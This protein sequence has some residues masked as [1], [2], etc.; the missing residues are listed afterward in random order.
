MSGATLR[1]FLPP[2]EGQ[3]TYIK[4]EDTARSRQSHSTDRS[5]PCW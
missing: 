3:M 2:S 1:D 4:E 5:H